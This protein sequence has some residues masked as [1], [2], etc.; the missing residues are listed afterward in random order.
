MREMRGDAMRCRTY[1]QKISNTQF[2]KRITTNFI[3]KCK[4]VT[5]LVYYATLYLVAARLFLT[6]VTF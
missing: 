1:K 4:L 6:E 5:I 2:I 3:Y